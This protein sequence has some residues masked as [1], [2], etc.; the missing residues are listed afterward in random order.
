[1]CDEHGRQKVI[2]QYGR[3]CGTYLDQNLALFI[4]N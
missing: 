1:M 4:V 3:E 2:G